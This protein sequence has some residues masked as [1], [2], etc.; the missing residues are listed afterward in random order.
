MAITIDRAHPELMRV[1]WA[2]PAMVLLVVA[3]MSVN[4]GFY[5]QMI[6]YD[7]QGDGQQWEWGYH[8]QVMR[9]T[10][11]VLVGH[12]LAFVTGMWLARRYP[13]RTALPSASGL[14]VVLALVAFGT[15]RLVSGGP[16]LRSPGPAG[17]E[18]PRYWALILAFPL[19]AA[20]GVG[21]GKL[22]GARP[23][24]SVQAGSGEEQRRLTRKAA[25]VVLATLGWLVV[26]AAGL[27]E[28]DRLSLPAVLLWLLPPLAAATVIGMGALSL[29][30]WDLNPAFT[31]D[32]GEA[33]A[34][35]LAGCLTAWAVLLNVAARSRTRSRRID[36]TT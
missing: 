32:W 27:L 30:V 11:G 19:F 4:E 1:L 3:L 12:V 28:D 13:H 16:R 8:R 18:D 2:I 5:E 35:A 21:L 14:G 29:D 24:E 9:A 15:A 6:N 25:V 10:S 31:G 26:T 22:I 36:S 33:A 34:F 20:A 7:P 17:V 23:V